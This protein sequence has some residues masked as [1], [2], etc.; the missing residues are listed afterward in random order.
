MTEAG[1][2]RAAPVLVHQ[3]GGALRPHGD[4]RLP[5]RRGGTSHEICRDAGARAAP[6]AGWRRARPPARRRPS[7]GL[8]ARPCR[9]RSPSAAAS[10]TFRDGPATPMV[11]PRPCHSRLEPADV[12]FRVSTSG[13][14]RTSTKRGLPGGRPRSTSS[15]PPTAWRSGRVTRSRSR[16]RPVCPA[17]SGVRRRMSARSFRWAISRSVHARF[18]QGWV[19][20]PGATDPRHAS[21]R[22]AAERGRGHRSR[23]RGRSG[24]T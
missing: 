17:P 5:T 18:V 9:R 4:A 23:A 2:T 1:F 13:F 19:F 3:R 15:S 24:S 20:D 10:C 6:R 21:R 11:P 14:E 8:P 7:P 12:P 16:T 22:A